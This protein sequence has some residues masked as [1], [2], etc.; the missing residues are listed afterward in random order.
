MASYEGEAAYAGLKIGAVITGVIGKMKLL[1]LFAFGAL[2]ATGCSGS[3][4]G[5]GATTSVATTASP[6]PTPVATPSGIRGCSPECASGFTKPGPLPPGSY[7]TTYFLDGRLTLDIPPGWKSTED[8]PVEFNAQPHGPHRV[9]FW[10]DPFPARLDKFGI[11]QPIPGVPRTAAGELGWFEANPE[12]DVSKPR[13][14]TIGVMNLPASVIDVAIAPDAKNED[15]NCPKQ[16]MPCVILLGWPNVQDALGI[17]ATETLR[18][19]LTDVRYGGKKHLLAVAIQGFDQD[20]L[21]S[22][23]DDGE[24]VIASAE[25]PIET[26]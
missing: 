21:A 12:L 17:S 26:A 6:S 4:T 10:V 18:L 19:Y 22:L 2:L 11:A 20:A 14:G 24:Q 9:V 1:T 13:D 16:Y 5:S 15:P 23:L 8:Q 3:S 7:T 25:A